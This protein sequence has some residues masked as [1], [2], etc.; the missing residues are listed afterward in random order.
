[1]FDL[2]GNERLTAWK[3]FRDSIETSSSPLEDVAELWSRAPFVSTFIDPSKPEQWPDPWHL[4]LDGKFDDL[5]IVLGMLYT[6]NLTARFANAEFEIHFSESK[7]KQLTYWLVINGKYVLN[8]NFKEVTTVQDL[9]EVVTSI[10]KPAR[11]K[12]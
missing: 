2:Y 3:Q 8:Y 11:V 6:L 7:N 1:M 9:P 10:I 4:I 12:K 5:A